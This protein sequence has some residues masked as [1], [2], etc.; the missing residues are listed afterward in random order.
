ML[1]A[2]PELLRGAAEY[3][4]FLTGFLLLLLLIFL[5]NGIVGLIRERFVAA[6]GQEWMPAMARACRAYRTAHNLAASG[7]SGKRHASQS[8]EP[9]GQLRWSQERCKMS[10]WS[11]AAMKSSASSVRTAQ[12]RPRSLTSFPASIA[13]TRAGLC[14]TAYDITGSHRSFPGPARDRADLPKLGSVR[15]NDRP[16]QRPCRGSYAIEELASSGGAAN[17]L[18]ARRGSSV[19]RRRDGPAAVRRTWSLCKSESEQS[20]FWTSASSRSRPRAGFSTQAAVARRARRR[21]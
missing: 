4:D 16:R 9:R 1:T 21:T 2:L 14:L 8:R 13:P 7:T 6:A 12:E 15:G 5:P 3:K 17:R 20:R 19:P 18:R 10:P 11:S